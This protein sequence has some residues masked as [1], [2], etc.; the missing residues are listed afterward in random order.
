MNKNHNASHTYSNS[1]KT[2]E[3]DINQIVDQEFLNLQ[4]FEDSKIEDYIQKEIDRR[5]KAKELEMERISRE[6]VKSGKRVGNHS[7]SPATQTYGNGEL[8][9]KGN[10]MRMKSPQ[11]E[12]K[13]PS[14]TTLYTPGLRKAGQSQA[15]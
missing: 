15:M 3:K 4:Q 6:K 13:S 14:D 7:G 12:V 1:N 9:T 5:W 8:Q 10:N 2:S 11:T